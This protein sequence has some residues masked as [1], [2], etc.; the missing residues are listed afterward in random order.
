[1][2]TGCRLC[3][4]LAVLLLVAVGLMAKTFILTGSVAPYADGRTSVLLLPDERN[5]VLGEMRVLLETVQAVTEAAAE[6]DLEA[7]A[8]A[9]SAVGMA[10]A[11]GESPALI[12][13]LPLEFKTLGFAT[14]KAFDDLADTA[15]S[16]DDPMVVVAE[17]ADVMNNCT[18]C[19]ASYRLGIEGEAPGD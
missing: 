16:T 7:A 10:A 11:Q 6:N 5:R 12:G 9:A 4:G 13:K 3:W 19:H 8:K 1:M 18:A 2:K 17:M 14:H 15:R